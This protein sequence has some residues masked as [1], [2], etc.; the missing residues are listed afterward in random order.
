MAGIDLGPARRV[1]TVSVKL[2]ANT[3]AS[4]TDNGSSSPTPATEAEA[5]AADDTVVDAPLP[6]SRKAIDADRAKPHKA[7][8][9]TDHSK[10]DA[11]DHKAELADHKPPPK[12]ARAQAKPVNASVAERAPAVAP[13]QQPAAPPPSPVAAALQ[14]MFG[15]SHEVASTS[16]AAAN[17]GQQSGPAGDRDNG[18]RAGARWGETSQVGTTSIARSASS[19]PAPVTIKLASSVSQEAAQETLS[20]LQHQ[21]PGLLAS[22][23]VRRE[24][25]GKFGVFYRVRVGPLSHEAADKVCAQL[26]AAGASCSMSGG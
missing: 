6:P 9:T 16:V 1:A 13:Q 17:A 24:D 3:D 19:D 11:A 12:P 23:V 18:P 2:P 26:K 8:E 5:P 20:R 10:V 14:N 4:P 15:G 22:G 25:M 7:A 21:F